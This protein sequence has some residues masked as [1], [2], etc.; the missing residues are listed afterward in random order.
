[1]QRGK[2]S[3]RFW[4]YF[5]LFS[6][7]FNSMLKLL[8]QLIFLIPRLLLKWDFYLFPGSVQ[9]FE[10]QNGELYKN[11]KSKTGRKEKKWL[12]EGGRE[13][14]R[15]GLTC[16]TAPS[17]LWWSFILWASKYSWNG[18]WREGPILGIALM[19]SSSQR[20]RQNRGEKKNKNHFFFSTYH[21]T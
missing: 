13:G 1:M 14:G 8:T 11:Y 17:D 12:R 15:E 19:E 16:G 5:H 2:T 20:T 10:K 9:I 3:H 18:F 21:F 6:K 7:G 4:F